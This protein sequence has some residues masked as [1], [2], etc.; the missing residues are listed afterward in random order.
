M[1]R[2]RAVITICHLEHKDV[3]S[4]TSNLL[5]RMVPADSYHVSVPSPEISEFEHVTG[6]EIQIH[7]EES[8]SSQYET[9]VAQAVERS[10]NIQ[11]YGWYLQQFH[12]IKAL[13]EVEADELVIWDADCVPLKHIP[14]FTSDGVPIYMKASENHRPYFDAIERL[15]GLKWVQQQSF[16]I[17]GFPI[18]KNWVEDFLSAIRQR[19][20]PL[21]WFEAIIDC[22][23]FN[24][25]S[26]FSEFE[27]LGTWIAN[28]YE[29][30]WLTSELTWE[31][32]GQSRFGYAHSFTPDDIVSLGLNEG[33]DIVSFENWDLPTRQK[34]VGGTLQKQ[35]R[36]FNFP[37]PFRRF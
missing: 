2:H 16:I 12:K 18:L 35:K 5:P 34:Y 8:I 25:K 32:R 31:R 28:T 36:F 1:T 21:D 29:Q 24:Q 30:N 26:G 20:H 17:P 10:G 7:S 33:L 23:D 27:T 22:I 13:H 9:A 15:L 37:W 11:R 14:L 4:L 19:H 3:W 6:R